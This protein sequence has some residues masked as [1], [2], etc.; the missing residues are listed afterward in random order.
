MKVVIFGGAG[1]IGS[2]LTEFF[3]KFGH[4]VVVVDSLITGSFP[5]K[6]N[7]LEFHNFDVSCVSSDWSILPKDIDIIYHLAFPTSLCKRD[8]TTQY[9][10][11]CTIGM[12]KIMEYCNQTCKSI[13]YGSSISVYGQTQE[14]P[15][16]ENT[17]VD[18]ILFYGAHK[19]LNE[20]YLKIFQEENFIRFEIARIAD[21]FGE[22]DKRANAINNFIKGITNGS[23]ITI[24]GDGTQIRTYTYVRDI[25]HALYELS[26]KKLTNDVF[27][28]VGSEH[29]TISNLLNQISS[30]LKS[31]PKIY[32]NESQIDKRNYVF[33]NSKLISHIGNFEKVGFRNGLIQ[34]IKLSQEL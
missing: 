23:T 30:E 14:I 16:T 26:Q 7:N 21:V 24:N 3:L 19:F 4:K 32:F 2:H 33:D 10:D 15:I 22:G 8:Y 18:P 31:K 9:I 25:A 6:T 5:K 29:V 20:Q 13:I 34:T 17:K 27:N 28:I 12:Y 1:F 11:C